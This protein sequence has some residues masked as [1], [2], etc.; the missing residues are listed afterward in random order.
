MHE[1]G[2]IS[3]NGVNGD[4][5]TSGPSDG[6]VCGNVGTAGLPGET[7]AG[8][9]PLVGGAGGRMPDTSF[10]RG[11]GGG[12]GD[13]ALSRYENP[14]TFYDF[15]LCNPDV[16]LALVLPGSGGG[17]GS[18]G[19][20]SSSRCCRGPN[21]AGGGGGGGTVFIVSTELPVVSGRIEADGGRGG[22]QPNT[23]CGTGFDANGV[24]GQ[25]GLVV[26]SQR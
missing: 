16:G 1:G 14:S 8:P 2:V 23:D 17:G 5:S 20:I 22:S 3:A 24:G 7:I 15:W 18:G 25:D 19:A 12:G 13:S 11:E 9:I 6:A 10:P 21:G 26:V 4:D